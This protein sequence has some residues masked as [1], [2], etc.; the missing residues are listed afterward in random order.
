[1]QSAGWRRS[2]A[3][4]RGR[5]GPYGLIAEGG[6]VDGAVRPLHAWGGG[7]GLRAPARSPRER[8]ALIRCGLGV[9]RDQVPPNKRMKQTRRR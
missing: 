1:M 6:L 8:G 9:R 4:A 2:L 3:W 5:T 7:G